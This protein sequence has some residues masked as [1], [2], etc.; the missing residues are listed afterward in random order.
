MNAH[1]QEQLEEIARQAG[2]VVRCEIC[3]S[4]D[5]S[6][7]NPVAEKQAYAMATNAWK[8]H[9]FRSASLEEVRHLMASVLRDAN[10]RCPSCDRD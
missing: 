8:R 6:A 1:M 2:A 7:D 4:N 3:R 5:V 10:H 9:E